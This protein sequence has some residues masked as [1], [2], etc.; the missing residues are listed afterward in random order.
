MNE[1]LGN[2]MPRICYGIARNGF[3]WHGKGKAG[4]GDEAQWRNR[5]R[6]GKQRERGR[7]RESGAGMWWKGVLHGWKRGRGTQK[8]QQQVA[9]VSAGREGRIELSWGYLGRPAREGAGKG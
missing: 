7:Q 2:R 3:G 6:R 9:K 5:K 1:T 8:R 4:N